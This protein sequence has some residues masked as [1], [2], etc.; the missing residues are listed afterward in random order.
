MKKLML[1][2]LGLCIIPFCKAADAGGRF[3]E[4]LR[5]IPDWHEVESINLADKGITYIPAT[6]PDNVEFI[7]VRN[8]DLSNNDID[9]ID[10]FAIREMPG[11]FPRLEHLNLSGNPLTQ[12]NVDD[13]K[14]VFGRYGPVIKADNLMP[15]L[16]PL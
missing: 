9:N 7:M 8:L 10:L 6:L 3:N 1:I 12:E 4:A 11:N 13:L 15:P 16:E 5:S 2:S 14:A